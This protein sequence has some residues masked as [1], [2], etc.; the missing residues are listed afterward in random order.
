MK[1]HQKK[2]LLLTTLNGRYHHTSLALRYLLANLKAKEVEAQILEFTI[3][4][5]PQ[6]IVEK[7]LSQNPDYL[8]ISVAI[9]NATQTLNLIKL[10]KEIKPEMPIILGGPE[11]AAQAESHPLFPYADY[12]IEGEG[13]EALNDILTKG[14]QSKAKIYRSPLLELSQ[15]TLPYELYT[16]ED[17]EHRFVYVETTRGCP[18]RCAFC[19]SS[20]APQ[21]RYFPLEKI[22]PEFSMLIKRG[23]KHFKFIDRTFNINN[24][25][26]LAILDFFLP[27]KEV[28]LHFEVVPEILTESF[29][30]KAAQ[31]EQG[32]LQFEMGVQTLTPHVAQRID[33]YLD[34]EKLERNMKLVLQDTQTHIHADLIVGL[35][36]ESLAEIEKSF[37]HLFKISPHEIQLGVLKLLR[38]TPIE[39]HIKAYRMKFSPL[40]PYEILENSEL[41]YFTIQKFRR[42]ARYLDLLFNHGNFPSLKNHVRQLENPFHFFWDFSSFAFERHP[43]SNGISLKNLKILLEDFLH[44]Q[45]ISQEQIV[46]ITSL[47]QTKKKEEKTIHSSRQTKASS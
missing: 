41:D 37:N 4:D 44:K 16:E 19:L 2:K 21:V 9:W 35:P 20:L 1:N 30:D 23:A 8:G 42:M 12:V 14:A 3:E 10:I 40:P 18:Y 11:F 47:I 38:G 43:Q 22:L 34:L 33:R 15:V 17:L 28:F 27:Y 25:R 32:R 5:S 24:E 31:F 13:E 36:G 29:I 6:L 26:A 46:D 7:I 45:N 39:K